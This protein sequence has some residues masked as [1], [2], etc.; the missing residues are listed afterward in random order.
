MNDYLC[1]AIKVVKM[2]LYVDRKQMGTFR[3]EAMLVADVTTTR[4]VEN[5]L[6]ALGEK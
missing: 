2:G 6:K 4:A 3:R 1:L 5:Y